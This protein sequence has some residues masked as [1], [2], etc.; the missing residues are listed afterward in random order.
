MIAFLLFN[1]KGG[2]NVKK[3]KEQVSLF[4]QNYYICIWILH[5]IW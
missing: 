5:K 2:K 1:Y 4:G 3:R